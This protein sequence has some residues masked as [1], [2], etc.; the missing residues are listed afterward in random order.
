[1]EEMTT[2]KEVT[3]FVNSSAVVFETHKVTGLEIKK[4][5]ALDPNSELYRKIGEHLKLVTNEE[6]VEIHNG[7]HFVDFPPTPVS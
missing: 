3:I 7:E 1:M 2:R 4:M 5:A 6:T